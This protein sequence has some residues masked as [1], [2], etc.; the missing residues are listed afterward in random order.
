[1]DLDEYKGGKKIVYTVKEE[2]VGFDYESKV[3]GDQR[4]GYIITNTRI[5]E[6]VEVI[7]KKTWE[8]SNNEEGKRPTS[9]TI[10]LLANG[11]EKDVKTVTEADE[12]KW[13]LLASQI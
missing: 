4:L 2:T 1:M 5:P 9:I 10:R 12:W 13:T 11:V 6:V 3:S 8:D 7:G